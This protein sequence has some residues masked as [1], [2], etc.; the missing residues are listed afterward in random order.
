MK[1]K[2]F[3]TGID[4]YEGWPLA[5]HLAAKDY[6]VRGLD[7]GFRRRWVQGARSHSI[8]PIASQRDR[9]RVFHEVFAAHGP[10][11]VLPHATTDYARLQDALEQSPPDVV[12]HMAEQPSAPFS[13]QGPV[14]AAQTQMLNIVGTLNLLHA[15]REVC[16]QAL[17]IYVSTMGEYGTPDTHIPEGFCTLFALTDDTTTEEVQE[18]AEHP[19]I[20]LPFPRMPGS[21]YHASKVASSLNVHLVSRIWRMAT[22]T[23]MQGVVYGTRTEATQARPELCTRFDIDE[24]F[25][26]VLNRFVGQAILGI[27]LTVYGSGGQ[28]RGF[29]SLQE[30]VESIEDFIAEGG[31]PGMYGV[32]NHITSTHSVMELATTVAAV[33]HEFEI[34]VQ[35]EGIEN[36]R[37]EA[38]QHTYDVSYATMQGRGYG[39]VPIENLTEEIRRMFYDLLPYRP[40]LEEMREVLMPRTTWTEGKQP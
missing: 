13:M 37:V 5:C 34:D 31:P 3:I 4:G 7:T 8:L 20:M 14:S 11:P 27:P 18:L 19:S 30:V 36:P 28:Q 6:D 22:L 16:P 21:F 39:A 23:L 24:H 2:V 40:R 32:V 25:G 1:K 35:I 12:V 10:L 29:I 15:M 38:E 26:T 9:Q 33:A 17:L